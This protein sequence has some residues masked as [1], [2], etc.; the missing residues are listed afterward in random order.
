MRAELFSSDF[1]ISFFIFLS[2]MLIVNAYYRNFQT[3][4][5]ET[6]MRNDMYSKAISIASL[7]ATTSGQ[8]QYWDHGNVRVLGLYD[9]GKFNLTKFEELKNIP[10]RNA[11]F[12][13]G[14]GYYNL[15][16]TLTENNTEKILQNSSNPA[17]SYTYGTSLDSAEQIIIVKRLGVVS[18]G[19]NTRK[20][21][22][23]V[24]LWA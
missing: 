18:L 9:S 17:Y 16:I 7:L 4:I 2:A 5:A 23:E 10:Y 24:I 8:P 14:S 3:E 19:G 13:L 15:N 21:T 12:K 20:V 11:T 1:I 6:S 22:L